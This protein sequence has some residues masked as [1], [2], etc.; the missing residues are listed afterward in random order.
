MN[1]AA[2]FIS[3]P[4]A[5]TL[6]VIAIA[7]AGSLGFYMLPVSPLPEVDFPTISVTTVLPGASP[8]TMA[9]S[10]ATPLERQFG[11]IAGIS[12]MTSSNLLGVTTITL[13]FDLNRDIDAAARD[14]QAAINAAAGN[15]PQN[16]PNS[17]N[18]KKVNPSDFPIMILTLTSETRDRGQMFDVAS[19][20][21]QQKLAQV[22]GV[23]QV[24]VGGASLPGVRVEINPGALNKYGLGLEDVRI[25]LEKANSNTPTGGFSD[26]MQTWSIG[27]N[28][29]MFKASQYRPLI[30]AYRNGAAV[31]LGDI[32]E[33]LDSVEDTRNST[34]LNG[35]PGINLDIRRQPGANIVATVDRIKALLP[36][37]QAASPQAIKIHIW[38]DQTVTIRASILEIEKTL[39][40]S[41]LLVILVVFLFLRSLRAVLIPAIVVPISLIGTFGVMY[42][43]GYSLNNLSLMALAIATC[44]LVDDAIVVIE[45]VTR[46]VEQGLPPMRAA[47]KGVEEI[48]FTIV[49]V[50]LSLVT[51]FIPL[52]MMGGIIGRLFREFAVTLALAVAI[53]M[54]ISLTVTPVLCANLLQ[55]PA[56]THGRA[57]RASERL[58]EVLLRAYT[59]S[60][61]AVL[62]RPVLT[63]AVTGVVIALNVFLFVSIPKGFF[64]QQDTGRIQG[65]VLGDQAASFHVMDQ[66]VAKAVEIA[67]RDPAVASAFGQTGQWAGSGGVGNGSAMNNGRLSVLLKPWAERH[68][69]DADQV[70]NRLRPQLSKVPGATT[71][72]Q[73]VQDIRMG[74]RSAN[75]QY[76]YTLQSENLAELLA[77]APRL[78]QKL[79]SV[80]QVLDVN[81]D[82]QT[83]GLQQL[84]EYDRDTASR[85]GIST[86][87]IDN[88]LYDAFG[89]RPVSTMYANLNQYHVIME[90]APQYTR[91][92]ESLRDIYIPSAGGGPIPLSAIAHYAPSTAPLTVNHQGQFP[93]VT[94]SFNLAP[95]AALGD[96][97][98]FVAAAERDIGL[99]PSV[100][101]S[102]AGTAAAFQASLANQPLLIA[103]ALFSVYIVLGMLYESYI[104]PVTILSTLP[105][106]GLGAVLALKLCRLDL[107][108]MALI[109]ILLLIGIVQKN[110]IIMIDFALA[111][112]RRGMPPGE[113]ILEACR[114]RFR[115]IFMTTMAALLGALPLALG[116]GMGYEF[117]RPLGITVIGGLAVSQILTLYTTPVVYLQLD[118]LRLRFERFRNRPRAGLGAHAAQAGST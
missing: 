104:Q 14:V 54:V 10:V 15:L 12:E 102:F 39:V 97:V 18:Y 36:Q 41:I 66:R 84:I 28:D 65:T 7:I 113:A 52:L 48:G 29:Q 83:R 9:S 8:E 81:S 43:F 22:E 107:S 77:W 11:R 118:R 37:L 80:P 30:I 115:P 24:N 23:G 96:A 44:F 40:F 89:Q 86:Q 17:P 68:G 109:G 116:T 56:G 69:V 4:V 76:Q 85:L 74:A 21:L 2:P 19:T 33:V 91:D 46:Y 31:R 61:T 62:R 45:N 34:Y 87:L 101:G 73:S 26:A 103:V 90:V 70:I 25:A 55:R 108:V 20:F 117:R 3:R 94:L 16:L 58:F 78:A 92:P 98:N 99:P 75:A 72:M 38:Q 50:S 27:A 93:A 5:T 64:P 53:S 114:L 112:E 32:A 110:A 47:L 13:Q 88:T 49:T 63:L 100:K 106:A 6:L 71:F 82:Q 42:L 111:C 59:S 95:G 105:S 60:L 57:Y 79:R 35:K 1:L 67:Q 51:V